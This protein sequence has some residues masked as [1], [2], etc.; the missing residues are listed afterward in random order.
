M[1][2]PIIHDLEREVWHKIL[3]HKSSTVADGIKRLN[4]SEVKLLLSLIHI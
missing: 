3:I 4:G 1:S 2:N